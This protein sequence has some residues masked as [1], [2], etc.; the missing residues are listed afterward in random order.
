MRPRP[1]DVPLN[2]AAGSVVVGAGFVATVAL[3]GGRPLA[4]VA[5]I[6][7]AASIATGL[8][9]AL[10]WATVWRPASRRAF[11]AFAWL[12]EHDLARFR[13]LTGNRYP[14]T[15]PGMQRYAAHEPERREDRWIR[16]EVLAATGDFDG[17]AAMAERMPADVAAERAE[18]AVALTYADW[19]RGGRGDPTASRAEAATIDPA[20]EESRLVAEVGVAVTEVRALLARGDPDPARPLREARAMLGRRADGILFTAARRV[21][22]AY[23]V[24]A[25]LYLAAGVAVTRVFF[26]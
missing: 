19:L 10:A 4:D 15:L 12:G 11:E 17:S 13:A 18:R 25:G 3:T 6:V 21:A 23:L 20:D 26:G 8:A 9:A 22:P 1:F 24:T 5:I 14:P 7:V 16:A 2:V